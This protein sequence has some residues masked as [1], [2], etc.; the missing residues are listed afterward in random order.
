MYEDFSLPEQSNEADK[1]WKTLQAAWNDTEK[2]REVTQKLRN[3]N[4]INTLSQSQ[5]RELIFRLAEQYNQQ[6][7]AQEDSSV[8]AFGVD[9]ALLPHSRKDSEPDIVDTYALTM[10]EIWERYPYAAQHLSDQLDQNAQVVNPDIYLISLAN[11][12]SA[13][14][15]HRMAKTLA[16]AG[17]SYQASF[18]LLPFIEKRVYS[19]ETLPIADAMNTLT[20]LEATANYGDDWGFSEQSSQKIQKLIIECAESDAPALV[21]RKASSLTQRDSVDLLT[22]EKSVASIQDR[23]YVKAVILPISQDHLGVYNRSGDLIGLLPKNHTSP[24]TAKDIIHPGNLSVLQATSISDT[25][26]IERRE[27]KQK[28]YAMFLD[29][30]VLKSLQSDYG[31]PITELTTR[32]Q[33]WFVSSLSEYH[34]KEEAQVQVFT[35]TFGLDGARSFLSTEF[36]DN[37]RGTVLAIAEKFSED[38]AKRIFRSFSEIITFAQETADTLGARFFANDKTYN[39]D[40]VRTELLSRAKDLLLTAESAD[41]SSIAAKLLRFKSDIVL[42]ASM[43][44]VTQKGTEVKF[45][46]IK[47]VRL[48]SI[49]SNELTKEDKTAMI[50]ILTENWSKQAPELLES[51]LKSLQ[52]S[53]NNPE[54]TFFILRKGKD[55]AASV[56]FDEQDDGSLY[57]G[58]LNVNDIYRSAGIGEAMFQS[59]IDALAKIHT[60]TA[61]VPANLPIAMK[62]VNDFGLKIIGIDEEVLSDGTVAR[63]LKLERDDVKNRHY[64]AEA[65]IERFDLSAN[66]FSLLDQVQRRTSQRFVGTKYFS[67]PLNPH[68][69]FIAFEPE[70]T[71]IKERQAA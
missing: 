52:D 65:T 13:P 22:T 14:N 6:I 41:A 25:A 29:H 24:Y 48:E 35:K 7:T 12:I 67:D 68:L 45:E 17:L 1:H 62:Y 43:F 54:S 64:G 28:G 53:F 5:Q 59:T 49:Q 9:R 11:I 3:D 39:A 70:V 61:H 57:A 50:K 31:F 15:I 27:Q 38:E 42:F 44:K 56:R 51:T 60:I 47:D 18:G 30:E 36:G 66:D 34:K 55:I 32:E 19:L 8:D 26:E 46:D 4:S 20:L 21:R 69:R 10:K 40:A 63:D 33:L 2:L 16:C 23:N 37:F 71:I 58:S